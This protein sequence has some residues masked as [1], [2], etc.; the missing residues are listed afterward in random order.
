MRST[1]YLV[2]T[3][4]TPF[5][6]YV[7]EQTGLPTAAGTGP[8]AVVRL[9]VQ[10]TRHGIVQERTTVAGK[11]VALVLQRS[12]YGQELDS[13][14]GF[15]RIND[16]AFTK[17]AASFQRAFEGVDYTFNWFY[18]DDRDISYFHSGRLPVRAAGVSADLPRYGDTAYDWKGFQAF[19][20]GYR[21]R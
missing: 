8:P 21:V 11:P 10:R 5:D 4:C 6:A 20:D 12:T 3:T 13:A 19:A 2:G 15:A 14:V 7:H 16:P 17:D 18:A 1:A 9:Q